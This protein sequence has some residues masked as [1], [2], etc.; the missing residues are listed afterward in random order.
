ML[1]RR[2]P[3]QPF[4]LPAI[5]LIAVFFLIVFFFIPSEARTVKKVV[6]EFYSLEQ[7]AKF[8]SSWDLFHSSMKAHFSRDRYISDRPHTFMNHFGVDTFDFHLNRPKKVKN[9]KMYDDTEIM[10]AYEVIVT[11]SYRG[12]Y[13]H[14]EFIQYV[15]VA[16]EEGAWR[17]LWD[18]KEE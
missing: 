13:G 16:Y 1:R 17:I 18:Y 4:V 14:F 9:W 11:K 3:L 12:T 10:E 5:V 8:S 6:N 2:N 15:Y 7:D